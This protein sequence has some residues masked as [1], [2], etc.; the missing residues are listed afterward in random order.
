VGLAFRIGKSERG[1]L[2]SFNNG[3]KVLQEMGVPYPTPQL[4]FRKR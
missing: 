4:S 2:F 1:G 3:H